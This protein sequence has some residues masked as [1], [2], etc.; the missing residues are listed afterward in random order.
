MIMTFKKVSEFYNLYYENKINIIELYRVARNLKYKTQK[1]DS[2]HLVK[3]YNEKDF[4]NAVQ[5]Y[6][7]GKKFKWRKKRNGV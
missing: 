1:S 3:I 2:G 7:A 4:M 6:E 5:K